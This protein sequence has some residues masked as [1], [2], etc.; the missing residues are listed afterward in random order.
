MPSAFCVYV[1]ELD[2]AAC[3][4]TAC[5]ARL[6]GKP[7]VYVGETKKNPVDRFAEHMAGGFLSSRVVRKHGLRLRPRLYR[8]WRPRDTREE[9]REAE[10]ML[11]ERLRRKG[12]CVFGGH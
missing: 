5:A 9:S 4:R 12:F 1:I 10:A 3:N 2:E 11:A 6:S 8:N 7:H